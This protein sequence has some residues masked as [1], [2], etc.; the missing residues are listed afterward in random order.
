MITQR[1]PRWTSLLLMV[2]AV[3]VAVASVLSFLG[4]LWWPLDLAANFRPHFAVALIA[5]AIFLVLAGR[6]RSGVVVLAVGI[7]NVAV[8]APL[9]LP[10]SVEGEPLGESLRVM[11]FNVNGLNDEY[12]DVIAYIESE[13]PDVVFL[14][15]ATFLWEDALAAAD[16]PYRVEPGRV[17]P[18]DFG[19][20]AL[21]PRE[22]EFRTFGFANS[23]PR[24]VEVVLETGG[25]AVRI[26]GSHPLSPSTEERARLR[27]AQLG[28]ARDWS[29][30]SGGRRIVAGDLNATPWSYPF[31]RLMAHGGLH[32]SQRGYGLELS[33]PSESSPII[34]VPIDHVLYSDGLRVVDRRLGPPLG[35][36][37]FPVVVDLAL[38]TS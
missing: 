38:I 32:N 27:D 23:A 13:L 4:G 31:R 17:E 1:V 29:A 12:A 14:H 28:F 7:A 21:V 18:L 33:F 2:P 35:S 5:M 6:R 36:D 20:L 16:L 15:E 3:A 9:F 26:L 37:H 22:A 24:A 25:A 8:V 19:T 11:S 30:E 34:R 10:P